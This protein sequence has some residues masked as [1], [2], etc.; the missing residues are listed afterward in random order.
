MEISTSG[1]SKINRF[2]NLKFVINVSG[3]FHVKYQFIKLRNFIPLMVA[4]GVRDTFK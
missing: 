2:L 3:A 1:Q 4:K